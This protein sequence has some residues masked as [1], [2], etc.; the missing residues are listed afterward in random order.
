MS[1]SDDH[2]SGDKPSGGES[3][4]QEHKPDAETKE[5]QGEKDEE[6]AK[7][8]QEKQTTEARALLVRGIVAALGLTLVLVLLFDW[9]AFR[10]NG[11][12][13]GTLDAQLRGDP[14]MIAARVDG[15]ITRVGVDDY[16][17]VRRGQLLY[18]IERDT[19]RSQENAARAMAAQA[20]AEV[21][22]LR[23]RILEQQAAVATSDASVVESQ[24]AQFRSSR[25]L[26][27][28]VLLLGTAGELHRDWEQ[29]AANH[30]RDSSQVAANVA[31]TRQAQTQVGV[32]RAQLAAAEATLEQRRASVQNS[33]ITLGYTQVL[34]PED[35]VVTERLAYLGQYTAPGT[36]LINFISLRTVWAV[37]Y[38]REE[39]L[40]FMAP[41]QKAIVHVD[42]YPQYQITG[43][44]DSIGP[45]AQ[46]RETALP[47]DRATG[48]F[49]KVVQRIPVKVSLDPSWLD[50]SPPAGAPP[51]LFGRLIPGLSV[52]MHVFTGSP[53]G[54]GS[55]AGGGTGAGNIVPTPSSL[56]MPPPHQAP[57]E[58][59]QPPTLPDSA[60]SPLR[61]LDRP[62]NP[63][64]PA[65]PGRP[66]A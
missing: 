9:K 11:N 33:A 66:G 64:L 13:T 4:K 20:A 24:A 12:P 22:V 40:T 15:L 36:P 23:A 53:V 18:E 44:V 39:Q 42:A 55:G 31:V 58:S 30:K 3:K 60:P 6:A 38:Y 21:D 1:G 48:N 16:A 52:E 49:T 29:A 35:G 57:V 43:R 5:Q 34:A 14:V 37:G 50:P 41:G 28:Q 65:Q 61:P 17:V 47:P 19:Y 25:E 32:L 62:A 10:Y 8:A 46:G 26:E 2:E 27:R 63:V 59:Q 56:Q 7:Q 51:S 54:N 45:V